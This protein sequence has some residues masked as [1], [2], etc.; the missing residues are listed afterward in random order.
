MTVP[1]TLNGVKSLNDD[2]FVKSQNCSLSLEGEGRGEGECNVISS[3]LS[4]LRPSP[5]NPVKQTA[6]ETKSSNTKL[7]H[8]HF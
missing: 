2:A 3:H 4:H 5:L 7:T 6:G 8:L 1:V